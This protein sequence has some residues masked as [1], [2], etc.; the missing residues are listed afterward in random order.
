M[1][2]LLPELPSTLYRAEH[3][4][5]LDRIA[6]EDAG[7]PG[8]ELME[9]AGKAAFDA[10][11]RHWPRARRIGVV[12]G[13]GNNGGDGFVVARLADEAGMTPSVLMLG[14]TT[15]LKGDALLA[16]NK[17]AQSSVTVL[18]FDAASLVVFDVVVDAMLGTGL[19]GPVEGKWRLAIDWVNQA[20]RRFG[21]KVMALDIPSGLEAD[22][23]CVMGAAVEADATMTF[24]GVKQGLVTASGP[25]YCGEL[26]FN[27][28]G[29]EQRIYH[30]VSASATLLGRDDI[31]GLFG[32][33]SK[34]S[35]KRDYGHVLIV[36]GNWGMP[37]AVH[38]AAKAALRAGAGMVSVATR[39]AHIASIVS[40]CPE[41]MCHSVDS[42]LDLQK[43]LKSATCVAIGPGLG[44]DTWAQGLLSQVLQSGL[45]L[46][47][48]AD[49]LNILAK[50]PCYRENWVLTPHP[51]EAAR[52][53][54]LT[55]QQ[56]Q[57]DRFSAVRQLQSI[58]GG[59][60]VLK[61]CGT[62]V[63]S[64]A[65]YSSELPLGDAA[66]DVSI[67]L[68]RA[69]NPGMASAGMGDV[70]T[71]VVAAAIVQSVALCEPGNDDKMLSANPRA[72]SAPVSALWS[73]LERAACAGVYVHSIAGDRAAAQGE[74]GLLASD[75][76]P[77][78]HQQ[79]N[80][81]N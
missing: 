36:G 59:V 2:T 61:G 50:E 25:D 30:Q 45:P 49:A 62:L 43:L 35:H 18:P 71:G 78:I 13:A 14:D 6:I 19:N 68:C 66:A 81:F 63:C 48:D 5:A 11:R 34:D 56:V 37:G 44:Q 40:T 41:V 16:F 9:R 8:I 77:F 80:A 24:I 47:V 26:G 73:P 79:V 1:T 12:C 28:L 20:K 29:V 32:P 27:D 57:A 69:G 4:R 3:V 42:P 70:L 67:R 46:V 53:L 65:G 22:T 58:Y 52:L 54:G 64:P 75:L 31:H 38:L 39:S 15:R 7:I 23:G 60:V 55:T 17:L 10:L 21:S 51:G 76:F 72:L 74:R 33:R